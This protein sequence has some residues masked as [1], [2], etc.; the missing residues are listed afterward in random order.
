MLRVSRRSFHLSGR[1][2]NQPKKSHKILFFLEGVGETKKVNT[3]NRTGE[4][5]GRRGGE[6]GGSTGG[7]CPQ[8]K[9]ESQ[10]DKIISDICGGWGPVEH[11]P[12]FPLHGQDGQA[13]VLHV[14]VGEVDDGDV[15]VVVALDM[16]ADMC[17]VVLGEDSSSSVDLRDSV[18]DKQTD[19]TL[20]ADHMDKTGTHV[21][22]LGWKGK[23]PRR[24]LTAPA[25]FARGGAAVHAARAVDDD[26]VRTALLVYACKVVP[27][28]ARWLRKCIED[29]VDVVGCV[30]V[31]GSIVRH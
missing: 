5:I 10:R 16:A 31:H 29:R 18:A 9:V 28:L 8:G 21:P 22:V 17:F 1:A 6:V 7:S 12:Y 11:P 25:E 27:R 13:L 24:M 23:L 3:K 19:G 14:V 15:A 26:A 4:G 2:N 30:V 20:L